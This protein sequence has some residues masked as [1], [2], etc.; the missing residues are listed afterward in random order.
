MQSKS[1]NRVSSFVAVVC[2]AALMLLAGCSNK[3]L[4]PDAEQPQAVVLSRTAQAVEAALSGGAPMYTEAVI[5]AREG[6]VLEL[7]DVI[8]VIPP[9][10]VDNDTVF[11]ISIPD[12]NVFFNDF[13]TDGLV[14]NIPVTVIMSYR[15]ADLSAVDESTIRV[16]FYDEYYDEYQDV[17]GTVDHVNKTVTAELHHFSA[18]AL[19][20]DLT[21]GFNP[22]Y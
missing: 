1:F 6:G 19:I 12:P 22:P 8:L 17:R 14:F 11:S 5:S 3:G 13:G 10:A 18:Y 4:E 2:G 15:D 20:S 16:A 21:G 9:G 7:F